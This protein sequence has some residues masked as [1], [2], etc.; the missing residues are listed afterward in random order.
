M[1]CGRKC[2]LVPTLSRLTN[3]NRTTNPRIRNTCFPAKVSGLE[4]GGGLL[5]AEE[6][7]HTFGESWLPNYTS[8]ADILP[9][10]R[11]KRKTV[12]SAAV[13]LKVMEPPKTVSANSFME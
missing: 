2:S 5:D 13:E 10:G 7:D 3:E 4:H 8:L 6:Q 9:C 1:H 11:S 12:P